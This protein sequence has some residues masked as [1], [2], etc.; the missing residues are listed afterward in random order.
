[1]VITYA[2][3]VPRRWDQTIEKHREG[4]HRAILDTTWALVSERGL[5]AVTMSQIAAQAG[6][7]RATLYKYFPDIEAILLAWHRCHVAG[8]LAHLA[9][10]AGRPGPARD[11]LEA[12]LEAYATISHR[13]GRHAPDLDMLL[14][15]HQDVTHAH[16]QLREL[17]EGLLAEGAAAGDLRGDVAPDELAVFCLRA[18]TAAADLPDEGAVRR[19]VSLA[20]AAVRP[21]SHPPSSRPAGDTG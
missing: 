21:A 2:R 20:L 8:H 14:H 9:E 1:M 16:E 3:R 12:V 13:R 5:R 17:L 18:L 19:L 11:R 7:G 6:I 10:L 4:V 15:H